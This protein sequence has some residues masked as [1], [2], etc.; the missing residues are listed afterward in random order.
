MRQCCNAGAAV[1]QWNH[2]CFGVRGV[3]KRTGSNSVH[4]PSIQERD[5]PRHFIAVFLKDVHIQV[6][7]LRPVKA[8]GMFRDD[9]QVALRGVNGG[10][11][12]IQPAHVA[13]ACQV[14]ACGRN[15]GCAITAMHCWPSWERLWPT[16][17]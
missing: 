14:V 9:G 1:V 3:S 16:K 5:V 17:E 13:A 11:V 4:G 15:G 2:A 7:D 10:C 12:E 6:D 8:G